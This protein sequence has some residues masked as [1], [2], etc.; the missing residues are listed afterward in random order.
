M[1]RKGLAVGIIL[2]FVGT[3]IIPAIAQDTKTPLP[4]SRG[5]WLYVGGSGPGN[6]TRIQDAIDN[7]STGDIVFVYGGIYFENI[8][9]TVSIF[10]I[11][12][13]RN[14]TIID[15]NLNESAIITLADGVT[16]QNFTIQNSDEIGIEI[17]SNY[18]K[19]LGNVI[20]NANWTGVQIEGEF[21]YRRHDNFISG[22]IITNNSSCGIYIWRTN[23]TTIMKNNISY[24]KRYGIEIILSQYTIITENKIFNNQ[25]RGISLWGNSRDNT[26][27]A[28]ALKNNGGGILI[29]DA[30]KTNI[31]QNNFEND[32]IYLYLSTN[33]LI[34]KNNFFQSSISFSYDGFSNNIW[35]DNY[36]NKQRLLPK[37]I[38]GQ[39]GV[40]IL[41]GTVYIPRFPWVNFD[42]HPAQEPYDIP[43]MR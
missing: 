19:I 17:K 31:S 36:W 34:T 23:Q 22:N 21:N 35:R 7:A 16:I 5:N 40:T 6:Y 25:G 18:T 42:R 27:F 24:S 20:K 12:E 10:L 30:W 13:N 33:N 29:G 11:G 9:I 3:C 8:R 43:G 2:L 41:H 38:I 4:T 26:I 32:G 15:S 14:A 39:I 1:K 28:N 37:P